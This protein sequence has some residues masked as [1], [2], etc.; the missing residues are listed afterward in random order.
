MKLLKTLLFSAIVTNMFI[1]NVQAKE[2]KMS[3]IEGCHEL[4][5]IQKNKN[6]RRLLAAQ[7]TSLSESLRAG[8]CLG[9]IA[10]YA[11]TKDCH[12]DWFDRAK[13]IAKFYDERDRLSETTILKQSC[14]I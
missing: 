10:E 14:K 2:P 4:V 13:F 6:E 7:T 1:A 12:S 9:V 5:N 3:L 11:R 8:Y